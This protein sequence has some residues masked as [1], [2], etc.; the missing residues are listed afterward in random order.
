MK[1]KIFPNQQKK[2]WEKLIGV[3]ELKGFYLAGGTAI[4]L[5]L[6]HR[7][8]I[9]FDFFNEHE[10]KNQTIINALSKNATIT[11]VQASIG[12]LH[13]TFEQS[14]IS[15]LHYPYPMLTKPNVLDGIAV[16]DLRDIVPM[17]LIAIAQRGAKKDFVDLFALLNNGWN[18]DAMMQALDQKFTNVNYNKMHILKS[19]SFFDEADQEPMPKMLIAV[20]WEEIKCFLSVKT[21]AFVDVPS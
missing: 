8:S 20:D 5:H 21:K 7:E 14:R 18:L 11:D 10:F 1:K 13:G 15:F 16:A 3:K 2:A 19:L 9:D 17:K 4:A 12:T 6:G